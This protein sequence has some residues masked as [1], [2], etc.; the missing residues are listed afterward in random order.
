[1]RLRL[2]LLASIAWLA[3]W[4]AGATPGAAG[5]AGPPGA[6]GA[7][8][9]AAGA[10]PVL[11]GGHG[12]RVLAVKQVD[13]RLLAVTLGTAALPQPVSVYILLPP[14]YAARP[15]RRYPTLYLLDGTS[16]HASDWTTLG[17]AERVIGDRPLITVM[18]DITLN[19]DGGGWCADWPDG[20]ERWETFH[21]DQLLPWV[22]AN[23]RTRAGRGGRAIAGLSQGGFC[24]LSYAARHPD[25]FSVALGYSGAPDIWYDPDARAGA[26]AI[27]NATEVGLD[28]VAPDTF[29]GSPVS[30]GINWASHDPATLAENLR[31]TRLYMYWGD[32]QP[33]PL[34]SGPP[35]LSAMGIE[36]AVWRD[37]NDFQARL[38]ALAIPAYFEDYGAGTHS[39]PYWSRDLQW[40]IGT[41]MDDF[42]HPWG[43]PARVTYTSG[44]DRYA[45]YGWSVTMRRSARELSTLADADRLGFELEGSGSATVLTPALYRPGARYRIA[46]SGPDAGGVRVVRAS[47][48]RRLLIRVPLGPSNPYPQYSPQAQAA[49]TESYTTS[50]AIE[51][52]RR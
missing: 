8:P 24:S 18:P 25:L 31:A 38:D 29:F 21:I 47:A 52:L 27:I 26:M 36:G 5:A 11:R 15:R 45:V 34:D 30:D 39:W 17:G 13:P 20:A 33:G 35:N 7:T 46:L 40:S 6:A 32:G 22:D 49:G 23:L 12:L 19:G 51:P 10:T 44:E 37:N 2:I 50:V 28:G 1:M 42:A 48:G 14:G 43:A 9:G 4:A 3:L 41:I 16:G